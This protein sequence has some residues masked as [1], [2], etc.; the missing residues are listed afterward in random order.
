MDG[1][2]GHEKFMPLSLSETHHARHVL[3]LESGASVEV[4]TGGGAA[5]EG[6]LEAHGKIWGVRMGGLSRKAETMDY[7][8]FTLNLSVLKSEA[9]EWCIE[10]AVELGCSSLRPI[11]SKF[12]VVQFEPN[13]A[14]KWIL[15]WQ[16]VANQALKQCGRLHALKIENPA[17]L[18]DVFSESTSDIQLAFDPHTAEN[19]FFS[20]CGSHKTL[21]SEHWQ[22][23]IGPEGGWSEDEQKLLGSEQKLGRLKILSLGPHVLRAETAAL[24]ACS[25]SSLFLST[26]H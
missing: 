4:L 8:P 3:R 23:F 6:T 12:S 21:P 2:H 24:A 18:A 15:R 19:S 16:G 13:H 7:L 25:L 17:T 20:F 1:F 5:Y 11:L 10:K 14:E 22:L 9:M 26:P